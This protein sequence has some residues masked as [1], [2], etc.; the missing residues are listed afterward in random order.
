MGPRLREDDE[1]FTVLGAF[2]QPVK[3]KT[4]PHEA[5]I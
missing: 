4:I 5:G 1:D 3:L 2:L